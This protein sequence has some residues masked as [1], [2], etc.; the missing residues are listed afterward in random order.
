MKNS[1]FAVLCLLFFSAAAQKNK[2][3]TAN[4]DSTN[5]SLT[6]EGGE[7]WL[8]SFAVYALSN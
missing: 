5:F 4:A 3:Y 8:A 1:L 6:P 7:H 2:F